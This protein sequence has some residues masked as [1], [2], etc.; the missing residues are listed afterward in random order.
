MKTFSKLIAAAA[1]AISAASFAQTA[2]AQQINIE[3][4]TRYWEITDALRQNQLLTDEVWNSFLELQGNKVY[5]KSV[6]NEPDLKAYRKAVE[7]VY[8]PQHD[9]LLQAKLK[10]GSWYYVLVNDYKTN[11][12]KHRKFVQDTKENPQYLDL[13]YKLAYEYLPQRARTRVE[14]LKLYYCALGND[15]TSRSEGIFFSINSAIT[16]GNVKEGA[17]EAHEIHHQIRPGKDFGTIS[18]ADMGLMWAL[19]AIQNEG[20]ADQI[21]KRVMLQ[22]G[23]NDAA[24]LEEWLLKPAPAII[25]KLDTILLTLAKDAGKASHPV[26]HY[27]QMFRGS[28]GHIPG[29]YMASVIERNGYRNKMV[30]TADDLFAFVRLYQ[31][32][33]AKDKSN[34]P[35]FAKASMAYLKKLEQ[36]YTGKKRTDSKAVAAL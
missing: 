22:K 14:D 30:E 17:L 28:G 13:M 8:M 25:Q 33:A 18:E 15:A 16:W 23:G 32:A 26:K 21:D 1:L 3:A 19:S 12:A 11:E 24:L 27:S 9:S 6:F 35:V 5:V 4:A 31:K 10:A 20:I 2:E 7:V 29:F 36:K 34:A